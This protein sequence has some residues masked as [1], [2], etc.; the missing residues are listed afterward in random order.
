MMRLGCGNGRRLGQRGIVDGHIA[1]ADEDLTFLGDDVLDY[2]LEV[3]DLLFIARHEDMAD[4]IF[5]DRRQGDALLSH[6][7]AEETV[8]DLHQ[9]ASAVT[10]QRIGADGAAMRQVL[11]YE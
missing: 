2:L 11:E 7:F 5:A 4:A 3:L 6:L 1:E 10:H 9:D 8:G